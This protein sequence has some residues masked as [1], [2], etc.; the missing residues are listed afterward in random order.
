MQFLVQPDGSPDGQGFRPS[1]KSGER[2]R[3]RLITGESSQTE[4]PGSSRSRAVLINTRCSRKVQLV[5]IELQAYRS[6][7]R[8]LS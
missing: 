7:S 6:T 5:S 4:R 2:E 1:E 8:E 3:A